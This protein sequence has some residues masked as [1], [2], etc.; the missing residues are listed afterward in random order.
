MKTNQKNLKIIKIIIIIITISLLCIASWFLG[1]RTAQQKFSRPNT[2][3]TN[4]IL[5]D[6][7]LAQTEANPNEG[8]LVVKEWGLR[9]KIPNGLT[10]VRYA[11]HEDKLAFFAKPVDKNVQYR[12][13]YDEY[14][15][16]YY[17]Y[18]IGMLYRSTDS[19]KPKLDFY[20]DGKKIGD[21]YYYTAWSFNAL[22][23]GVGACFGIYGD[24]E[25]NCELERPVF[26]LINTSNDSLLRTIEL[27][28]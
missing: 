18:A 15:D 8:Y 1:H 25:S 16:G 12:A 11:I 21:Y 19:K 14:I 13:N 26:E 5:E 22:A 17:S 28:Q 4:I 24:E 9:F 23:T 6:E 10:D 2:E 7:K 20:V 27:A 3:E